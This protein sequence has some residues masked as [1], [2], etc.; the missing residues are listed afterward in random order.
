MSEGGWLVDVLLPPTDKGVGQQ[1]VVVGVVVLALLPRAWRADRTQSWAGRLISTSGLRAPRAPLT[2]GPSRPLALRHER[3]SAER[4]EPVL[5]RQDR[6]RHRSDDGAGSAARPTS[7]VRGL[8]R[9]RAV[10]SRT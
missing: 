7:H 4:P 5:G 9:E 2:G 10:Q 8:M 3:T 6:E 1:A